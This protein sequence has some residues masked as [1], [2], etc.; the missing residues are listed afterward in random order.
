MDHAEGLALLAEKQ[1]NNPPTSPPAEAATKTLN[2]GLSSRLGRL[3]RAV[4]EEPDATAQRRVI[5]QSLLDH[6]LIPQRLR[7]HLDAAE[8]TTADHPWRQALDRLRVRSKGDF[9]GALLGG[10]GTG[11]SQLG[12]AL[13]AGFARDC[14]PA[15]FVYASDLFDRIKDVFRLEEGTVQRVVSEFVKPDLLVV[16]E[17]NHGLSEADIRYLHRVVC[18]RYDK[19]R[20]T[21]LI[22]NEKPERFAELVGPRVTSR[23]QECG[24][25]VVCDW[26]SFREKD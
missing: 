13:V 15:L 20:S 14:R 4:P 17:V 24:G 25:I 1:R 3:V 26:P 21:V 9:L 2:S 19:E 16:D 8:Q 12:A 7:R 23:M 22:S 10:Y 11:K 5:A 18:K 6:G